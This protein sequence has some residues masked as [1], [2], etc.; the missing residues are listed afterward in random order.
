[1]FL[2]FAVIFGGILSGRLLRGRRLGF[3]QPAITAIIWLLLFLL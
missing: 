3:V 1:M 2:I